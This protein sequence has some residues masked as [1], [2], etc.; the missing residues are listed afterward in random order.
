[1]TRASWENSQASAAIR[2]NGLLYHSI[3]QKGPWEA[4]TE[5]QEMGEAPAGLLSI[6]VCVCHSRCTEVRGELARVGFFLSSYARD[7]TQV[8]GHGDEHLYRLSHFA[9]PEE[10]VS[11]PAHVR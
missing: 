4:G 6:C 10:V 3:Q 11:C 9:S 8:A 1:M 2:Q 7:P 5:L